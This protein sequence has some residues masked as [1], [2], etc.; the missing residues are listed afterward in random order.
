MKNVSTLLSQAR[1]CGHGD[2]FS[3]ARRPP[4]REEIRSP[5]SELSPTLT[6]MGVICE[7][8]Q[9]EEWGQ[10]RS[11]GHAFRLTGLGETVRDEAD[12]SQNRGS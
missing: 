2:T 9:R 6:L 3:S 12:A 11:C 10:P 4:E 7:S 5:F 8:H 1:A